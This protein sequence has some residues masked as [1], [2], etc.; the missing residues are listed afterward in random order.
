MN[1]QLTAV[2][3]VELAKVLHELKNQLMICKG[4]LTILNIKGKYTDIMEQSL[5]RSLDIIQEFQESNQKKI[6]KETIDLTLLLEEVISLINPILKKENS[7]IIFLEKGKYYIEGDYEKL[8][9]VFLNLLKNSYEAKGKENLVIHIK[10]ISLKE[11]YKIS[12][13]DNGIGMSEETRK[14]IGEEYYTTKERGTGLGVSFCKKMI[15]IHEGSLIYQSR[16]CKGTKVI[17][18][19]PK[20]KSHAT[21][22]SNS[23][24]NK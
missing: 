24:W 20:K 8:K 12:I 11:Y 5:T 10:I 3:E 9:Q 4:Y 17:I 21:F 14:R 7:N 19:L 6:Q 13:L 1:N 23:Y 16:K 15:K 22:N 18:T 2:K